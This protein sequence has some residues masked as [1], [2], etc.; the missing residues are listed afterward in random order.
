[1]YNI[2]IITKIIK[3]FIMLIM[4]TEF[5]DVD[6]F[7]EKYIE[8]INDKNKSVTLTNG[9]T[10]WNSIVGFNLCYNNKY[11]ID[12]KEYVT[13]NLFTIYEDDHEFHTLHDLFHVS[14][15]IR[16]L[17]DFVDC[18]CVINDNIPY[19]EEFNKENVIH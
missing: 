6:E 4:Y 15:P 7:I 2:L 1:M 13:I 3:C 5:E 12:D 19:T 11:T 17:E 18:L 10:L 9:K 14:I 16:I 8:F